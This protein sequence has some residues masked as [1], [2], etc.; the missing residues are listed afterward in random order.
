MSTVSW[1]EGAGLASRTQLATRAPELAVWVL[2]AALGVQAAIIVTHLAGS[3]AAP[4]HHDQ[5]VTS[6][7]AHA[8]LNLAALANGHLFGLPPP[9]PPVDDA[10]APATNMPLVLTGIIAATDP[11]NGLAII[12]TSATNARIYPVGERVPGNARVHAVYVDRVLLERNGTLEALMLP[13]KF[14]GGPSPTGGPAPSPLDRMQR[15]IANEPGLISDVLRPQ[16]VFADGKLRG[17]R[18]YPGQNAR[19]FASLGLRNGDLVLAI[20]GTALD[21]AARGNEIFSSLGNSDQARVTVMRNGQQQD[22]TLNMSQI[23]SQAEQLSNSAAEQGTA[24]VPPEP[25]VAAPPDALQ[26]P[27]GPP[28]TL[29]DSH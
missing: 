13:R 21:D 29:R 26:P 28:R 18:V 9:P 27:S 23:A 8:P 17:Y 11:K 16:P 3:G 5:G 6:V 22:L 7:A 1:L 19:A 20:N 24:A 14:G 15:A 2:A 25:V 12:G 4:P 10:N